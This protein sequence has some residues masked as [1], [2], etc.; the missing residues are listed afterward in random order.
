M[1]LILVINSCL[2][3]A[4]VQHVKREEE[5]GGAGVAE[6]LSGAAKEAAGTF[7]EAHH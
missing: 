7:P 4:Q 1:T 3:V 5:R 2:H 6:L